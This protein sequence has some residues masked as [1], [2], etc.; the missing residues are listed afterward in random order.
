VYNTKFALINS[1]EI[2]PEH[3]NHEH[4]RGCSRYRA[5]LG[6]PERHTAYVMNDEDGRVTTYFTFNPKNF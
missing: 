5:A 4:D 6:E 1:Q 3:K 2:Y